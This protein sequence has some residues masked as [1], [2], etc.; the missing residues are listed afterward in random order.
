MT[1]VKSWNNEIND[2]PLDDVNNI[3]IG[4][5]VD[6]YGYTGTATKEVP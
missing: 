5:F 1:S 2:I 4:K 3:I 6:K